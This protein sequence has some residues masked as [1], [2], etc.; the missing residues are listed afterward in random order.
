MK[1]CNIIKEIYTDNNTHQ[2]NHIIV[3]TKGFKAYGE[4]LSRNQIR[5][6]ITI[7]N[8]KIFSYATNCECETSSAYYEIGWLN[9]FAEEIIAFSF[10]E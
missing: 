2:Y 8:A 6:L 1:K 9:I 5:D 4:F 3:Y 10:A 7:K